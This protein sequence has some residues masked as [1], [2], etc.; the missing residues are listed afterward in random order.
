MDEV[1]VNIHPYVDRLHLE[2]I[3]DS[4]GGNVT[5][6]SVEFDVVDTD[7]RTVAPCEELPPSHEDDIRNRLRDAGYDIVERK[8]A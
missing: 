3:T 7:R 4:G 8:I 2:V 5:A 1:S 6:R